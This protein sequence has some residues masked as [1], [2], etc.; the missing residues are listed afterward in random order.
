MTWDTERV[1]LGRRPAV[2]IQLTLDKCAETY[3]VLPCTANLAAGLECF[4]TRAT[5]QDPPNFNNTVTLNHYFSTTLL[6]GNTNIPCIDSLDLAPTVINPDKGLGQRATISITLNDFPHHDRGIDPYVATRSYNPETQGTYFGKLLA[7]NRHISGRPLEVHSGYIADPLDVADFQKRKYI[8]DNITG[9]D[10]SGKVTIVAKDILALADDKRALVP[11]PSTGLLVGAIT[12]VATTLTVTSGTESEYTSEYIRIGEEVILAPT[13]NRTANVFANLTR[14]SFNTEAAAHALG[15]T[16]QECED[17]QNTN[18]IDAVRNMLLNNASIP[19]AYIVNADWDLVRD[20]WYATSDVDTLITKPT[21]VNKI[22]NQ[23]AE[24]YF[25]QIW[26]NEIDQEIN[27]N[28]I[29]AP[30]GSVTVPIYDDENHLINNSVSVKHEDKRRLTRILFYYNP[31]NPVKIDDPEDYQSLHIIIDADAESAD[32]YADIRQKVILAQFVNSAGIA[33][34]TGG[35]YLSRFRDVPR[36]ITFEID[37]KGA[38]QWTGATI[39][40]NSKDLQSETGAQDN[41]RFQVLS[42]KELTRD[43]PGS[44]YQY[45]AIETNFATRY[46]YVGP[47]TLVDYT[48]ESVL[49][50]TLYGWISDNAGLMGDNTQAYSII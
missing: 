32:Q 18:C 4:N 42:V 21:G 40:I 35:R 36:D 13:A 25:F 5:C 28:A 38:D 43:M 44:T 1:K 14:A 41:V 48:A 10:K 17:L 39:D 2:S 22:I 23:L 16:V 9:P 45:R 8:V 19:T 49:N 31:L 3:G 26:W 27:I 6:E 47:N 7:R 46:G 33:A 11:A 30:R 29:V 15:D 12:D 34:Q 20:T 50:K 24:Q 37:A